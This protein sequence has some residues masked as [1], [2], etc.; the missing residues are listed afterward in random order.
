MSS[1]TKGRA[2][3]HRRF[4]AGPRRASVRSRPP[5]RRVE[6]PGASSASALTS[7]A[8]AAAAQKV[9]RVVAARWARAAAHTSGRYSAARPRRGVAPLTHDF[10]GDAT[11]PSP[12]SPRSRPAGTSGSRRPHCDRRR[13]QLARC[14]AGPPL[15]PTCRSGGGISTPWRRP[16][17]PRVQSVGL[18]TAQRP[19][20]AW[21]VA[22]VAAVVASHGGAVCNASR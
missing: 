16:A 13:P 14:P 10:Q 4:R 18:P 3:C 6:F 21:A 8:L 17:A 1:S 12:P 5:T 7:G 11:D 9:A 19:T 15:Q 20:T 2:R 22:M